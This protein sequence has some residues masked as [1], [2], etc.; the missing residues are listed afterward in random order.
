MSHTSSY[1]DGCSAAHKKTWDFSDTIKKHS[2]YQR[3]TKHH[4]LVS[5]FLEKQ[6]PDSLNSPSQARHQGDTQPGTG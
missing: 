4:P 1:V 6:S 5:A 3:K 2:H